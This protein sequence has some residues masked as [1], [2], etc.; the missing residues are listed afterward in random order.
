MTYFK[1]Q[2]LAFIEK[3]FRKEDIVTHKAINNDLLKNK[4]ILVLYNNSLNLV[5]VIEKENKLY[6]IINN[7]YINL[8]STTLICEITSVTFREI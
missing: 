6:C 8:N 3:P 1:L 5:K 2:N 7:D 4:Y